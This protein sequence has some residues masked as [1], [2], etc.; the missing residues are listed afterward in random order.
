MSSRGTRHRYTSGRPSSSPTCTVCSGRAGSTSRTSRTDRLCLGALRTLG[1]FELDPLRLFEAAVALALN[2][3]VVHEDVGA[4]AVL[5]NEAVA[6]LSVEPLHRTLC[7]AYSCS[8]CPTGDILGQAF[9]STVVPQCL[10]PRPAPDGPA[11][12]D[13][14]PSTKLRPGHA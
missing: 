7:H 12:S 1:D 9:C 8:F 4:A 10:V 3:G 6:L 11:R 2:R 5:S 14:G 13:N